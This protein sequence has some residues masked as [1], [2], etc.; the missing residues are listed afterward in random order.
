MRNR[1]RKVKPSSIALV[2]NQSEVFFRLRMPWVRLLSESGYKVYANAPMGAWDK[3]IEKGGAELIHWKLNRSGRNPISEFA[4]VAGL[5]KILKRLKPDIVQNF[6]TKPNIYVPIATKLSGV[7]V[8]VS[9]VTGLGYTFVNRSGLGS[10][11]SKQFSMRMYALSNRLAS[12][13]TFQNPDDMML[14]RDRN[15]LQKSKGRFIRGGSGVDISEY[16]PNSINSEQ[17]KKARLNLNIPEH[18]FVA[19]FVGR[20]QMDKGPKE[21]V[22]AARI[23]KRKRS[24]IVFL[25][26]GAPDEGNI[27]SVP[28]AT[29]AKWKSEGHVIF[30]GRREDVPKLMA[31]SNT[32]VTPT[33]YREG[34]PRI[35]LEASASGLPLIGTDMPG[36]REA[37]SDQVNGI[38]VP[39]QDSMAIAR[40]VEHLADNPD[41]AKQYGDA[42]LERAKTEFDHRYVVGEYLK[43]YDELW[44]KL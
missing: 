21:F 35:L 15:G 28:A 7:P 14:L 33:F 16:S 27:R 40:A 36:V 8:S 31:A 29:L 41:V 44:N 24:D 20:L 10:K 3:Q 12:E 13:V 1:I 9:T 37:I 30:T 32:I 4:S 18:A 6:H 26:V 39:T 17:S 34:L 43:L 11:I 38:L 42:A 2:V 22:E 25:A 19:L 23:L 5:T